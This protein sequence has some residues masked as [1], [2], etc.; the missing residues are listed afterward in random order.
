MVKCKYCHLILKNK[1]ILDD[2]TSFCKKGYI[3]FCRICNTPLL[4]NIQH[5]CKRTIINQ[6]LEENESY[7]LKYQKLKSIIVKKNTEIE[8]LKKQLELMQQQSSIIV[9]LCKTYTNIPINDVKLQNLPKSEEK[10]TVYRTIKNQAELVDENKEEKDKKVKEV[11]ENIEGIIQEK[12]GE[13]INVNEEITKIDEYMSALKTGRI[14]PKNMKKLVGMRNSLLGLLDIQKYTELLENNL[15]TL[16]NIFKERRWKEKRIESLICQAF[17]PLDLRLI[18]YGN[19]YD[20]SVPL[21]DFERIEMALNVANNHPK[22]Y[23]PFDKNQVLKNLR[24]YSIALFP[25]DVCLKRVLLNRY[26]YHNLVFIHMKKANINDPYNFYSLE[27]IRKDKRNWKME[28]RLVD[29]S[30]EIAFSIR[31]YCVTIFRKIYHDVY[32]DNDFRED[33]SEHHSILKEDCQQLLK[34]LNVMCYPIM[35]RELLKGIIIENATKKPT[36]NDKCNLTGDDKLLLRQLKNEGES[37]D[38]IEIGS[39]LFDKISREDIK[40]FWKSYT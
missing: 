37:D 33:F 10:R 8:L 18:Y 21:D 13:K 24:N 30:A 29:I 9:N 16:Q 17:S 1:K 35:F 2:H 12:I 23:V 39:R 4:Q 7:K 6:S 32:N 20:L 19:Y 27:S 11:D 38:S 31:S 26:G 3:L 28:C 15:K 22:Q 36:K 5:N 40:E 34:N 25:L 14:Y